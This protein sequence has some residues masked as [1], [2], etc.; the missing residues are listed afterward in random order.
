MNLIKQVKKLFS[1][2]DIATKAIESSDSDMMNKANCNVNPNNSH[3]T[4]EASDL[5]TSQR[6]KRSFNDTADIEE[7]ILKAFPQYRDITLSNPP[8]LAGAICDDVK[9]W[10]HRALPELRPMVALNVLSLLCRTRLNGNGEQMSQFLIGIAST[11]SG[12]GCHINYAKLLLSELSLQEFIYSAPR[13][14]KSIYVDLFESGSLLYI[15]DEAQGMF[16]A[17]MSKNSSEFS[18]SMLGLLMEMNTSSSVT[19]PGNLKREL[20]IE[21]A[22]ITNPFLGFA[23]YSTPSELGFILNERNIHSGLLGRFTFFPAGSV[24]RRKK[25]RSVSKKIEDEILTRCKKLIG[26][27]APVIMTDSASEA[28]NLIEDIFDLEEFLNHPQLGAIY[29]RGGERVTRTAYLLGS[30]TGLVEVNDILYSLRL[31]LNSVE[32]CKI[33]KASE[34]EYKNVEK[35]ALSVASNVCADDWIMKSVLANKM[36]KNRAIFRKMHQEEPGSHYKVIQSL[37]ERNLLL[38]DGKKVKLAN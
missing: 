31:F 38:Q 16:N 12:K 37:I 7:K 17:M 30:E 4:E 34:K 8:G 28:L 22:T 18:Q 3:K 6:L 19:L 10:E 25:N 29:A 20:G 36:T 33:A 26:K 5:S 24:E 15:V 27:T 2:T 1:Q 21:N 9:K 14:D 32:A 13:S 35:L 23:G 11:A